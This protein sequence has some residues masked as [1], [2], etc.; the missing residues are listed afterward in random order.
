M[1]ETAYKDKADEQSKVRIEEK[2]CV[3]I[4]VQTIQDDQLELVKDKKTAK[5]MFDGLCAI[6]ERKSVAGYLLAK[7]QLLLMKYQE[8][9]E[10]IEH[11]VMFDTKVRELKSKGAKLEELDI[12]VHLFITLPES[13]DGLV[14]A[15]E[16]ISQDEL[17]LEFVETRLMDGHNKRC[18]RDSTNKLA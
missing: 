13:Y 14:T 8:G 17:T 15:L 7:K 5:Q 6:F 18:G 12:I 3:S 10:M 2:K 9:D 11:F 1:K 4:L 16:T